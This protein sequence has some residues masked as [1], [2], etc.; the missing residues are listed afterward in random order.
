VTRQLINFI[1]EDL[2]RWYVQIVRPR[3][4]LEEESIEKQYAYET[5]YYC[6]RVLCRLMAPF[7]PHISEKIYRNLRSGSDPESIHMIPWKEGNQK[8]VDR[9]LEER[10]AIIRSFDEAIANARQAGKRKLRWPVGTVTVS[11]R[12]DLVEEAF[13]TMYDLACTRA[14]ARTITVIRGTWDKI[15]WRAEPVMKKIGP[16]FGKQGPKVKALIE[17][18]DGTLLKSEIEKNGS[19]CFPEEEITVTAEHL[20]FAQLMP[21]GVFAAEMTDG[22][23]FVDITLTEDLEAEGYSRELIRRLQDMR[24]QLNLNVEEFISIDAIITD[25]HLF[26]LIQGRW[27]DL[28]QQEVRAV[29]M[30]IH[31]TEDGHDG[32]GLWQLD[33]EW[34][35]EGISVTLGISPSEE[36]RD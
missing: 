35:L 5:M 15:L 21:E 25:D 14:N 30:N 20:S 26:H 28:I 36:R 16:S 29:S 4:W 27:K 17:N 12:S 24:K 10:M 9:Q 19:Y 31:Q 3:M 2:S 22:T 7:C 1:L 8:L 6:I 13:R 33:R 32:E 18:A 34:D 23:V 11:A